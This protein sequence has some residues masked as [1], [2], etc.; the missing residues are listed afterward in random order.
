MKTERRRLGRTFASS[1]S[2]D[3]QQHSHHKTMAIAP[4]MLAPAPPKAPP[5]HQPRV[6]LFDL[7]AEMRIETYKLALEGVGIHVLPPN[8]APCLWPHSLPRRA[9]PPSP[10]LSHAPTAQSSRRARARQA[11]AGAMAVP[12]RTELNPRDVMED[13]FVS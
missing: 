1:P 4:R 5:V 13:G 8:T 7:P 12:A 6:T 3:I 9:T 2:R 10:P 11:A